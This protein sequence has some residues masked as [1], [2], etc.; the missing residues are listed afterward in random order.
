MKLQTTHSPCSLCPL[1]H[2]VPS[3]GVAFG[4]LSPFGRLGLNLLN[5]GLSQK[6]LL[7]LYEKNDLTLGH[8]MP[9]V[10]SKNNRNILIPLI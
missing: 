8:I 5:S 4:N 10:I 1:I 3:F 7:K 2:F 6:H 9:K